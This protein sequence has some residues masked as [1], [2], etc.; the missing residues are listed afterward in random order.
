MTGTRAAGQRPYT[1]SEEVRATAATG[2]VRVVRVYADEGRQ[3]GEHRVLVDRLWPRGVSKDAIDFDLWAKEVAP[4]AE[5]RRWY[6]H[7]PERFEEFRRRY[8]DELTASSGHQAEALA[9][10]VEAARSQPVVLLTATRDTE[11]SGAEVLR[12]LVAERT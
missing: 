7:K 4:S 12:E 10:L 11:R 1:R 2:K 8:R 9:D 3:P 5:L 6:G